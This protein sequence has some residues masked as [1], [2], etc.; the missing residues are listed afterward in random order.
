MID[1][2][3]LESP[4]S[5]EPMFFIEPRDKDPRPESDR[6]QE[7]VASARRD[8]LHVC[9]VL[10][11]EKRG[12]WALNLARKLGAWWGFPDAIVLGGG[13]FIAFIEWKD[14]TEMPK[15]H[16]VDCMNLLHRLGFNVAL[17][18]NAAPAMDWL[19]EC[20]APTRARV[21]A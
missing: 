15:Q 18:R 16:Q 21:A 20:G 4:L 17:F 8:G 14:G 19:R 1:W 11:G 13:A 10:N 7:W 9:A 12:Q 5:Q 6:Q 2:S 3:A